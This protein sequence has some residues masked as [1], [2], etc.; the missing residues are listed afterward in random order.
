MAMLSMT[1]VAWACFS[2]VLIGCAGNATSD[3][4]TT[5]AVN[6]L[7]GAKLTALRCSGTSDV[8]DS[9]SAVTFTGGT[10]VR[11]VVNRNVCTSVWGVPAGCTPQRNDLSLD[12]VSSDVTGSHVELV[13]DND[14]TDLDITVSRDDKTGTWFAHENNYTYNLTCS[15]LTVE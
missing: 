7:T 4:D 3:S 5:S 12:V 6:A 11:V 10:K 15:V 8:D 2:M 1:R 13:A 14:G 9:T